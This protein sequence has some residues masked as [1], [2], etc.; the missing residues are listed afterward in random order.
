MVSPA[1]LERLLR[2]PYATVIGRHGIQMEGAWIP[3]TLRLDDAEV[4]FPFR[5]VRC[6]IAG[7]NAANATVLGPVILEGTRIESDLVLTGAHVFGDL[8]LGVDASVLGT[9]WAERATVDG[10]L[11]LVDGSTFTDI[12]LVGA[13]IGGDFAVSNGCTVNGVLWGDRLRVGG[14]V[15]LRDKS[16]FGDINLAADI[17]GDLDVSNGST[18]TGALDADGLT[19][20]G[21]VFLGRGSTFANVDLT[22]ADI[23]GILDVS[24]G[25]TVTGTLGAAGTEIAGSVFLRR[26]STFANVDLISADIGGNL[27]VSNGSTV[28]GTLDAGGLTI[29]GSVLL[30]NG[31]TFADIYL[32]GSEIGGVLD[33]CNGSTVNGALWGDEATF[34]RSVFLLG[35][36]T[37][38]H[39]SLVATE[40]GGNLELSGSTVTTLDANGVT[41]A[42]SA[43]LGDGSGFASISLADS[44]IGRELRLVGAHWHGE[45]S[46]D[47]RFTSVTS[48]SMDDGASLPGSLQLDGFSYELWEQP[49]PSI[50]GS[51]W[52]I[53]EWLGRLPQFTPSAYVQL[54]SVMEDSGHVTIADDIRYSLSDAERHAVPLFRLDRWARDLYWLVSGYG[55]KPWRV[56][57]WVFSLWLIGIA[58]LLKGFPRRDPKRKSWR[59]RQ[60]AAYS[61]HRLLPAIKLV[62]QDQPPYSLLLQGAAKWQKCWL[63]LHHVLGWVLGLAIIG[64]LGSLLT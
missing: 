31:S 3:S 58:V 63:T 53:D 2:E 16:E 15:F 42:G 18:V 11:L 35:G 61:L 49:D 50:I 17:G 24:N 57:A 64:W 9:L 40:I 19:M 41:V 21:S 7:I 60:A 54:A 28:T 30:S 44:Q 10:S 29:G 43:L 46:M 38:A 55:H 1:F 59:F 52:F 36:S 8:V 32:V 33:V 39:V 13:D 12:I 4:P 56:V 48:F 34:A 23:G 51:G 45:G 26:G 5:C 27:D 22:S 20:G 62:Q 14:A 25:S 6:R 37:F 47:L